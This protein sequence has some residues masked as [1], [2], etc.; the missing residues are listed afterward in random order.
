MMPFSD[1]SDK[2]DSAEG[3]DWGDMKGGGNWLSSH[4]LP[5]LRVTIN[6][7]YTLPGATQSAQVIWGKSIIPG[8]LNIPE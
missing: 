5:N 6:P 7:G 8:S 4:R 1:K 2:N 3:S